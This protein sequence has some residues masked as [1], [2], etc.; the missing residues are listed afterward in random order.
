MTE[1]IFSLHVVH[2]DEIRTHEHFDNERVND[3]AAHLEQTDTLMNPVI[4]VE[5]KERCVVLDGATRV[6]AFRKLEY[7]DIIV[8]LISADNNSLQMRVWNHAIYGAH[9]DA[10]LTH[11]Q[12]VS[13][14]IM[15]ISSKLV[16]QNALEDR[17][18]L[19]GIV[20]ADEEHYLVHASDDVDNTTAL[21]DL[22]SAYTEIGGIRRMVD[23]DLDRV[24]TEIP[25]LSALVLFP[26][27]EISE[28]LQAAVWGQQLPAGITRFIVP[29]RVL[30]IHADL[31]RLR[32]NEPLE[33]KNTWLEELLSEK[34]AKRSVRYYQESVILLD[35]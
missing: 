34:R 21:N 18:A 1:H 28:V 33:E 6:A 19:C 15:T 7:P 8:Q 12:K 13:S 14:T 29:G 2:L 35:E 3:L 11:L 16:V 31:G 5:W 27:L 25:N 9:K 23:T 22:V 20:M 26:Q 24:R 10:L 30:R 4:A 32:T 17:E